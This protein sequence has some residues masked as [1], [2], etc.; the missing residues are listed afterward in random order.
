MTKR[1]RWLSAAAKA[2]SRVA[3]IRRASEFR[4]A[5]WVFGV[6]LAL[7]GLTL[8]MHRWLHAS[9]ETAV[10]AAGTGVLVLVTVVYVIATQETVRLERQHLDKERSLRRVAVARETR[11]HLRDL[12]RALDEI[13]RLT[14][15]SDI[16]STLEAIRSPRL[17]SSIDAAKLSAER[18]WDFYSPVVDGE[19]YKG[20]DVSATEAAEYGENW[21]T[22][23]EELRGTSSEHDG[24]LIVD[25]MLVGAHG[26]LSW[27]RDEA[28]DGKPAPSDAEGLRSGKWA[29]TAAQAVFNAKEAYTDYIEKHD[30]Q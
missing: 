26:A 24:Q 20:A 5:A 8:A 13:A 29:R 22:I 14:T 18:I 21:I 16:D 17:E 12:Q 25:G 10:Q 3:A 6:L 1:P 4:I 9:I 2:A 23:L 19:V 28:Y 27:F 7:I 30:L 15:T 11:S